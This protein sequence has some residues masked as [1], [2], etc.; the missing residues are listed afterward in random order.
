MIGRFFG[1]GMKVAP[2]QERNSGLLSTMIFHDAGKMYALW[3][4]PTI[5]PGKHIKYKKKIKVFT[6]RNISVEFTSPS[7]LQIDGETILNVKSYSAEIGVPSKTK[8]EE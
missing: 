7:A 4:F 8:G 2:D 5:F 6:G 1:G 3:R